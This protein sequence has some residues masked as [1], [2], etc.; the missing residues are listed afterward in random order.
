MTAPPWQRR[1]CAAA[2][3]SSHLIARPPPRAHAAAESDQ[4]LRSE[5]NRGNPAAQSQHRFFSRR[6]SSSCST[7]AAVISSVGLNP[8]PR[9]IDCE[10]QSADSWPVLAR[11]L[12]PDRVARLRA[13]GFADPGRGPNHWKIYPVDDFSD[14]AISDELLTIF[15]HDVYGYNGSPK[16]EFKTEKGLH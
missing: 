15:L 3:I 8:R 13:A 9:A 12:T 6:I 5:S 14:A 7:Q 10:A 16:L 2:T 11:I 4:Y 1:P